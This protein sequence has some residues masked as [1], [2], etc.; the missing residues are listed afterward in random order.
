MSQRIFHQVWKSI[1]N[2]NPSDVRNMAEQNVNV[3]LHVNNESVLEEMEQFFCPPHLSR[4]RRLEI[5]R[6]LFASIGNDVF[7][8]VSLVRNNLFENSFVV[9]R[10]A[11]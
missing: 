3:G 9:S 7:E 1:Q 5:F 6:N 8:I 11:Q 10:S 4:E 2:L